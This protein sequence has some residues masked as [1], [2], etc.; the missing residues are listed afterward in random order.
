MQ[1]SSSTYRAVFNRASKVRGN[2]FNWFCS[3]SLKVIGWQNR[4]Q[5]LRKLKNSS[6]INPTV[7]CRKQLVNKRPTNGQQ[8][9]NKWPT[10]GQQTANSLSL[11]STN[12]RKNPNQSWLAHRCFSAL[13]AGYMHLLWVLIGLLHCLLQSA[14][15]QSN[16]IGF[17]WKPLFEKLN[18]YTCIS[19]D[20]VHSS[21]SGLNLFWVTSSTFIFFY[22]NW[23]QCKLWLT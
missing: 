19:N 10:V 21:C 14:I 6:L 4:H 2:R 16:Y 3:T 8:S 5:F 20:H 15:G 13:G 7:D 1:I 23:L 17:G 18:S 9:A 22:S 11:L 12:E